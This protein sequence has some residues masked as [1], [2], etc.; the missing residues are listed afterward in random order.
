[1]SINFKRVLLGGFA[2]GIILVIINIL[3][4]IIF[5]NRM[6]QDVNAW[7]PGM[8]ERISMSGTAI[9]FSLIM[10]FIIGIL[11]IGCYAAIRPRFGPGPRT[12]TYSALFVWVLGGIFFSDYLMIGML[13][14][15]TYMIIEAFQLIAFLLAVLTGARMYT[16]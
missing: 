7:M 5:G 8:T 13:S 2:A 6:Q 16:E 14:I 9:A 3:V 15:G 4:Q 1:M 10:K 11:L 12:A